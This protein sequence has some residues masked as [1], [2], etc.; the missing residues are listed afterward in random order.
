MTTWR[1]ITLFGVG[2][3]IAGAGFA[4]YAL[5]FT[6][7]GYFTALWDVS[8][9]DRSV[10]SGLYLVVGGLV[11]AVMA[12]VAYYVPGP[13]VWALLT[14][15]VGLFMIGVWV[16][17]DRLLPTW[18]G[19]SDEPFAGVR[20]PLLEWAAG[21]TLLGALVVVV[22][23]PWKASWRAPRVIVVLVAG[24]VLGAG[25]SVAAVA[26][27]QP[28]TNGT[29][30]GSVSPAAVPT[31]PAT[32]KWLWHSDKTIFD[33]VPAGAGFVVATEDSL[34]AVDGT[35]GQ[36]RWHYHRPGGA[37]PQPIFTFDHG[38]IV[39]ADVDDLWFGFDA[40]TGKVLWHRDGVGNVLASTWRA[41]TRTV[42]IASGYPRGPVQALDPRTGETAWEKPYLPQCRADGS[43]ATTDDVAIVRLECG[44]KRQ[45]VLVGLDGATGRRLWRRDGPVAPASQYVRATRSGVVI[46]E[47]GATS[48]YV[49]QFT[50]DTTGPLPYRTIQ[51]G[52]PTG[53]EFIG[54]GDL[55]HAPEPSARWSVQHGPLDQPG[56]VAWLDT[57]I[58]VL[59]GERCGQQ[60]TLL[61]RAGGAT[62]RTLE[63]VPGNWRAMTVVGPGALALVRSPTDVVGY[64]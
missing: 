28:N 16:V 51:A 41:S 62:V 40:Y 25:G 2:L 24:V 34:I 48:S 31:S 23:T 59:T 60:L 19:L 12:L 56:S 27:T 33:I 43:A 42:L 50:G 9:A 21:I 1:G 44:D 10:E 39:V 30:A 35:T 8:V 58:A 53:N 61:D 13:A 47:E 63:C 29:T 37:P 18:Q 5:L 45:V 64:A 57:Q 15:V 46:I 38:G 20:V 32:Q 26:V 11:T 54:G 36:E 3:L 7:V 4:A 49:D 22:A 6:G 55:F 52:A 17:G 14:T